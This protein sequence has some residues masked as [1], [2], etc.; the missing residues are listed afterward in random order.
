MFDVLAREVI[1][2]LLVQR[3]KH[4]HF[5]LVLALF[6]FGFG[7]RS[8]AL[9]LDFGLATLLLGFGAALLFEETLFATSVF[10]GLAS[11]VFVLSARVGSAT[12][13]KQGQNMKSC[14]NSIFPI[15]K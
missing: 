14:G 11:V 13:L 2:H 8:R 9:L 12:N 5:L 6:A 10:L 3:H 1:E 15:T 4:L 7:L